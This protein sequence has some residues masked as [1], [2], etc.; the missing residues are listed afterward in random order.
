MRARRHD[1]GMATFDDVRTIALALPESIEKVGGHRGGGSSYRVRDKAFAW[2][3]GPRESDV[4]QLVALGRT[5]PEGDIA[6]VRTEDLAVKE[7]L[8]GS[9]PDVFF[10]IPHF[11]GFPAVLVRLDAIGLDQLEEVITDAWLFRAPK[12]VADAWLAEH[13]SH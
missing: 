8:L 11:D 6:A 13:P 1:V 2:E 5:W 12:R 7:A 10:S 9:F 4:R 3:R